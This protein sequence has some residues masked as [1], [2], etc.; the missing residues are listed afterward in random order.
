MSV[1]IG[2]NNMDLPDLPRVLNKREAHITPK[3]MS[4]FHK[5][6]QKDWAIEIKATATNSIPFSAVKPHQLQ[7]LLEAR[8]KKGFKHKL[9]DALR[10]RQPFDA[11][12][13]KGADTFVVAC[14]TKHGICLAIE[15]DNWQGARIDTPCAFTFHL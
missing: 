3:V 9:S 5:N 14:F 12:G 11:F 10:Q 2:D 1:I 6:Y 7:S 13:F 8:S 4:W 15:P